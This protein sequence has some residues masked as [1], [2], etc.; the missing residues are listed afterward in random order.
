LVQLQPSHR[1][2]AYCSILHPL[3][4]RLEL[5]SA[6][7]TSVAAAADTVT[8]LAVNLAIF[9]PTIIAGGPK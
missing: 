8:M 4:P 7:I 5:L 2:E 1:L 3:L 6:T 9:V